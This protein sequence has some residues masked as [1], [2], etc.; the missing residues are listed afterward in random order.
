M[1]LD[2]DINDTGKIICKVFCA[3]CQREVWA[4]VISTPHMKLLWCQECDDEM[5]FAC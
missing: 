1:I 4:R 2:T 3:T 5:E